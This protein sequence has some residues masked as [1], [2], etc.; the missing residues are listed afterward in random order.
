MSNEQII[1]KI[2]NSIKTTHDFMNNLWNSLN[3]YFSMS[4]VERREFIKEYLIGVDPADAANPSF[5][6]DKYEPL[7]FIE[8]MTDYKKGKEANKLQRGDVVDVYFLNPDTPQ[9]VRAIYLWTDNNYRHA[10]LPKAEIGIELYP[11]EVVSL[12]KTGKHVDLDTI[13]KLEED[14]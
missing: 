3:E 14:E 5:I 6:F 12:R 13:L 1:E 2:D 7:P 11:S 10:L 8:M 9:P 4:F